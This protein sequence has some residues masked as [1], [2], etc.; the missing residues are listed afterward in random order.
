MRQLFFG[1]ILGAAAMGIA[2]CDDGGDSPGT[3]TDGGGAGYVE[4]ALTTCNEACAYVAVCLGFENEVFGQDLNSCR[5]GCATAPA[6]DLQEVLDC[7]NGTEC[8]TPAAIAACESG[9]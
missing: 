9:P 3:N 6:D 4:G 2:A 7:L 5:D 1:A 8:S